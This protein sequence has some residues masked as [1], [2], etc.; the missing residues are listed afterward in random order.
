MLQ[1][2]SCNTSFLIKDTC[3][4]GLFQ[5]LIHF[6]ICT[7]FLLQLSLLQ[8]KI[9]DL[10]AS[11]LNA[12]TLWQLMAQLFLQRNLEMCCLTHLP[13]PVSSNSSCINSFITHS[14]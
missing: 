8:L 7:S 1:L 3:L 2:Y 11:Q 12:T 14:A 9:T 4:G 6:L 10:D 5:L 13:F